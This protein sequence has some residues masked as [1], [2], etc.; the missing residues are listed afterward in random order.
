[1]DGRLSVK[2]KPGTVSFYLNL[3]RILFLYVKK[4]N[5]T[6]SSFWLSQLEKK[7][8]FANKQILTIVTER[9]KAQL[10]KLLCKF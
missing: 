3:Y 5:Q 1:M 2:L 9:D 10:P 4:M 6:L 8:N 7:V